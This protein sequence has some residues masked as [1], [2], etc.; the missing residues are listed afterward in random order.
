M[1]DPD[2]EIARLLQERPRSHRPGT[3]PREYIPKGEAVLFETRPSMWPYLAGAIGLLL[4]VAL[5]AALVWILLPVVGDADAFGLPSGLWQLLAA[6]LVVLGLIGLAVRLIEWY[7]T[8]YAITNRRVIRKTGWISR[9]VVDARFERIQ[10]VSFT[11]TIGTRLR[12]FEDYPL[13]RRGRA[14]RP[15][16]HGRNGRPV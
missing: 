1:A 6:L 13:A 3:L 8:S 12:E 9:R 4:V 5:L 10:A 15:F 16:P 14:G 7:F 2:P 11:E